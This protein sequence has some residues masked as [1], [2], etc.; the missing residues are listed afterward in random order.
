M[1]VKGNFAVI[2]LP[3]IDKE[4]PFRSKD[5]YPGSWIGYILNNGLVKPVYVLSTKR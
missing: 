3:S 5:S 2:S 1:L 4:N